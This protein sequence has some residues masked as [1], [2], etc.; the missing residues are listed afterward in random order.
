MQLINYNSFPVFRLSGSPFAQ[1]VS[2]L[3]AG[4]HL[5]VRVENVPVKSLPKENLMRKFTQNYFS[6]MSE[7]TKSQQFPLNVLLSL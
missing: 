3:E 2:T 4:C 7:S 6:P 1:K 5:L